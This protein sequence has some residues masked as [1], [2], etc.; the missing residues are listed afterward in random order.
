MDEI[1]RYALADALQAVAICFLPPRQAKERLAETDCIRLPTVLER[2]S[3]SDDLIQ[4]LL[5]ALQEQADSQ[6]AALET[7]YNELFDCSVACPINEAAYIRRD[8]GA[9]L[10]DI[11]GFYQAFGLR[12]TESWERGDHLVCELE[13]CALLLVMWAN[14]DKAGNDE[15]AQIA[16][17]ALRAFIGDHLGEWLPTFC[18]RLAFVSPCDAYASAAQAL[19]LLWQHCCEHLSLAPVASGLIP[20]AESE[21]SGWPCDPGGG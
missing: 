14:A 18:E 3:A 17:D 21:E 15:A 2:C 10:G 7:A 20:T 1:S 5:R 13:C 9:I 12:L 8:K 6:P 16:E 19:Q 11:H 4:A